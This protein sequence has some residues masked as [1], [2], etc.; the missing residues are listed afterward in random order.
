MPKGWQRC[1]LC[2][3]TS[4]HRLHCSPASM[5]KTMELYIYLRCN[6]QLQ[7]M[8]T[9]TTV[10]CHDQQALQLLPLSP[11]FEES[12]M[13]SSGC[14]KLRMQ[15]YPCGCVHRSTWSIQA[16]GRVQMLQFPIDNLGKIAYGQTLRH[17]PRYRVH[18]RRCCPTRHLLEAVWLSLESSQE[19]LTYTNCTVLPQL[20]LINNGVDLKRALRQPWHSSGDSRGPPLVEL[21]EATSR[22]ARSTPLQQLQNVTVVWRRT[23]GKGCPGAATTKSFP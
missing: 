4:A 10:T 17:R 22:A 20:T 23:Q 16:V 18:P 1:G 13:H 6:W 7:S 5:E 8:D 19:L 14:V 3:L 21:D 9:C 2:T 15:A 11:G 12:K